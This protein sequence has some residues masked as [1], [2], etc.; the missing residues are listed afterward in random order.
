M[1]IASARLCHYLEC[2]PFRV[3]VPQTYPHDQAALCSLL[4]D[5]ACPTVGDC[6]RQESTES[7][8]S[9]TARQCRSNCCRQSAAESSRDAGAGTTTNVKRYPY[10]G[11]LALD[12]RVV[13]DEGSLG[14][15]TVI[16]DFGDSEVQMTHSF[17]NRLV[18]GRHGNRCVVET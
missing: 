5:V 6:V 17:L 10:R 3:G 7:R 12:Q 8:A 16:L 9:G 14:D 2:T 18:S 15:M 13:G 11:R 1:N 4:R